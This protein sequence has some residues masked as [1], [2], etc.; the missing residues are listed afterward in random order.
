[1]KLEI[2]NFLIGCGYSGIETRF[3]KSLLIGLDVG[4]WWGTNTSGQTCECN[5]IIRLS[6][7]VK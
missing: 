1:M 2:T 7:V 6:F 3:H 5:D 4:W